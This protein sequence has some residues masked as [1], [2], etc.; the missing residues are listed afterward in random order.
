MPT[1]PYFS[2]QSVSALKIPA[3]MGRGVFN[4]PTSGGLCTPAEPVKGCQFFPATGWDLGCKHLPIR[5]ELA[6]CLKSVAALT[7]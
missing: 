2:Q 1:S 6:Q 7:Q 5:N 4:L 3:A